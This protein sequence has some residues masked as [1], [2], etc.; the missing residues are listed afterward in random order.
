MTVQQAMT[1]PHAVRLTVDDFVLL[2]R[3]GAFDGYAKTELIDG[4]VLAMN[5]QYRAHARAKSRLFHRLFGALDTLD[6]GMEAIVE[7]SV[8][9]PPENMPEPDIVVTTEPGGD[10]PV[11]L[12][13]VALLI[14]ISDTTADFDLGQKAA[15][16]AVNGVPEYWVVDLKAE[17]IHLMWSPAGEGYG[18]RRTVPLGEQVQAVTIEGLAV[19]TQ[20][21]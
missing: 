1:Q 20:G 15:I 12:E 13:S 18:A 8:A 2:D 14:E 5:A 16:Y 11:P 4:V 9:M 10:G 7:P 19:G 17:A 21:L 3:S 6:A